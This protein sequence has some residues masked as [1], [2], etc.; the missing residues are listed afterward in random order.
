MIYIKIRLGTGAGCSCD[1][2]EPAQELILKGDINYLIFEC[3]SEKSMAESMKEKMLD[4]QK[5]YSSMLEE[6]MERLLK[7]A[8]ENGVKI[9]SNMG[10]TNVR[11]AVSIIQK[12]AKKH[13]ITGIKIGAVYGD[14]VI[15]LINPQEIGLTNDTL[16]SANAYLGYEGIKKLLEYGCDVVITGRIADVSLFVG[17]IAYEFKDK[18]DNNLLANATL[19]GR[20]ME[21]AGQLTG[22]Y[23]CD[24]GYKDIPNLEILGFPIA[25]ISDNGEFV[26]SKVSGTGGE[27]SERIVKEQL[28]YEVFDLSNYITPDAIVD[29]TSVDIEEISE[30]VVRVKGCNYV[31]CPSDYKVN[32]GFKN[33]YLGIGE[34]GYA[35]T[36]AYKKAILTKDILTK[37]IK[38]VGYSY[39]DLSFDLVGFNSIVGDDIAI[40]ENF[41]KETRVRMAVRTNTEKEALLVSREMNYMFT[42]GLSGGAGI[43][44]SVKELIGIKAYYIKKDK[45]KIETEVFEL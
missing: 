14:D 40:C 35:G 34:V 19:L 11:S 27:I 26:I 41:P 28:S 15:N 22:G 8:L 20:L 33:G 17:P 30:N 3:L 36:T 10:S 9:I 25:E 45:L 37:R 42:N 7:I 31:G 43:G 18:F 1:R 38:M 16:I 24:P 44:S 2:I 6:R 5:G 21:C 23:A 4:P 32:I 13:N 12:V 39:N 29:F